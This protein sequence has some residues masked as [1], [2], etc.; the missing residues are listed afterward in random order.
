M[1]E[2][3]SR[4]YAGVHKQHGPHAIER[5]K[6]PQQAHELVKPEVCFQHR[7]KGPAGHIPPIST[8]NKAHPGWEPVIYMRQIHRTVGE[9][10]CLGTCLSQGRTQPCLKQ[11]TGFVAHPVLAGGPWQGGGAKQR[12]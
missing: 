7:H 2:T 6:H 5:Y 10:K 9:L 4:Y 3:Q 8:G 1:Q 11:G 12:G